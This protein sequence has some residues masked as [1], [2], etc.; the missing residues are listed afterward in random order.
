[1]QVL[2][3]G[4]EMQIHATPT[5]F[6]SD[7]DLGTALPNFHRNRAHGLK[8]RHVWNFDWLRRTNLFDWIGG[9]SLIGELARGG[10]HRGIACCGCAGVVLRAVGSFNLG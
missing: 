5:L 8:L 1:M 7:N 6:D 10:G 3:A 4:A 2:I 9:T